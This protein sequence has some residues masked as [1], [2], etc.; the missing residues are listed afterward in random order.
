MVLLNVSLVQQSHNC[1]IRHSTVRSQ[2]QILIVR[3]SR[4]MDARTWFEIWE[5]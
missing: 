3:H 2:P 5:K 1:S 4:W